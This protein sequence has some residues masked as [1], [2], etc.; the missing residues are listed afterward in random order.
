MAIIVTE[1]VR[2]R[3]GED[4]VENLGGYKMVRYF[5]V[6][7][8]TVSAQDATLVLSQSA[9]P[10]NFDIY[11]GQTK[12][13]CTSR[14]ASVVGKDGTFWEVKCSYEF[15]PSK[16]EGGYKNSETPWNEEPMISFSN[17]SQ[18]V[19]VEA[20]FARSSDGSAPTSEE[21]EDSELTN[22]PSYPIVNSAFDMFDP[23]VTA[24]KSLLVISIQRA[25]REIDPNS[26]FKYY[27]TV[28][29][30]EI[31]I[32]GITIAVHK[33][34]IKSITPRKAFTNDGERYWDVSY[35]I[36]LD[37]Q[38]HIQSVLDVGFYY[39]DP[40]AVE[41]DEEYTLPFEIDEEPVTEPK[42]LDGLGNPLESGEEPV[43]LKFRT[44]RQKDFGPL[45]L[46]SSHVR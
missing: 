36:V 20:A 10:K 39:L 30:K 19:T 42:M 9:L 29:S 15:D 44:N 1:L 28:N 32:A 7:L 3:T 41:G 4:S 34:K 24:L 11:P 22:G 13:V 31:T 14:S 40:S 43:Y 35:E 18:S 38:T 21:S 33:A 23:G 17:E 37:A 45:N 26:F 27:D 2:K 25:E 12:Y 5:Q 16:I 6:I 46:P 8:D